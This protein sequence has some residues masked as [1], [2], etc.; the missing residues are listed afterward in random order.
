MP[1]GRAVRSSQSQSSGWNTRARIRS[2]V[3]SSGRVRAQ[4]SSSSDSGPSGRI[5]LDDLHQL[6]Q[7]RER[8]AHGEPADR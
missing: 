3:P 2:A 8:A 7:R 4:H 1:W 5:P 6:W